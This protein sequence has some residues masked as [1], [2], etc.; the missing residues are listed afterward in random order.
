[1]KKVW[2]VTG[3]SKGLGRAIVERALAG[4]DRVLATARDPTQLEGLQNIH[5]SDLRLFSLDVTDEGQARAAIDAVQANF[6]R[7]DVL[8]NNAGYASIAPFE[9]LD[10]ESFRDQIEANL[11][12]VVNMV[13]AAL[14]IM[15]RQRSGHIINISSVGGRVGAP[16]LSAYQAAKWAVG[17]FTE[18]LAKETAAFGVQMISVEPGGMRTDWGATAKG[19]PIALIEEYEPSVG[20]FLDHMAHFVGSEVGDPA[21]VANVVFDLSRAR[22]LPVHLLLGSDALQVVAESDAERQKAAEAWLDVSRSTDY[23]DGEASYLK[24]GAFR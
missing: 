23:E 22:D 13:R 1:M 9:Q 5:A 8:V 12:G 10:A 7:L 16:G 2:L 21:R 17:G 3:G 6:G 18:V 4:G 19:R 14:P 20:K 15:R 11:F 24:D